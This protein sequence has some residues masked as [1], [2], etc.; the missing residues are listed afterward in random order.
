MR[1]AEYMSLGEIPRAQPT[2]AP[3]IAPDREARWTMPDSDVVS[4]AV[5]RAA[6]ENESADTH[7]LHAHEDEEHENAVV[8]GTLR[9]P[10]LWERLLVDAAVIGS[11]E[12]WRNK[13]Q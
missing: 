13:L 11:A 1:F 8:D 9:A 4:D 7:A 10:R 3:P 6:T 2:G 5:A 12:R